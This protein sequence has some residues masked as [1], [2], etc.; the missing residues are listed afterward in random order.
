MKPASPAAYRKTA[1][2][3]LCVF[4]VL[5]SQF[6]AGQSLARQAEALAECLP[7]LFEQNVGQSDPQ[8]RYLARSGRYQIF[9]LSNGVVL[10]VAGDAR[11]AM[12]RTSLRNSDQKATVVGIEEQTAKT[13]Y[14]VGSRSDWKTGVP[15]FAAVKYVGV[16]PGIDLTY[17][18]KQRQLEYDFDLAPHANPAAISFD[19]EGADKIST[20][21]DGSLVLKTAAGQV[22][23]L[24]PLAYQPSDNGR[25]LISAAYRVHRNRVSFKLGSYDTGKALVI[26]PV[27]VY[28]TFLDGNSFE[29]YNSFL[30]DSAGYSYI[31][32]ETGVH[33]LPNYSRRLPEVSDPELQWRSLCLEIKP[34]RLL[35][36]LVDDCW[37]HR[38]QQCILARCLRARRLRQCVHRRR[39]WRLHLRLERKPDFLYLHI[40]H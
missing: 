24:K 16:Y 26:D 15:N 29:R 21:K 30:V 17:Y 9:L 31:V 11:D 35:P 40:S 22:R 14:L 37:W 6:C 23:W 27:M 13:N 19:I 18:S 8:V 3:V 12:L 38:L 25:R 28:G 1:A 7:L 34:G 36:C 5:A 39:N 4:F 32:G 10:K 20:D 2:S 33:R